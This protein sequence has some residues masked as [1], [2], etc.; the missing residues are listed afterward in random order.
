MLHDF[1]RRD[2]MFPIAGV[3]VERTKLY[4]TTAYGGTKQVNTVFELAP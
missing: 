3:V 1:S 2:G 4:G